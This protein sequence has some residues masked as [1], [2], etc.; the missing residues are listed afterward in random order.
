MLKKRHPFVIKFLTAQVVRDLLISLLGLLSILTKYNDKLV[1]SCI[2]IAAVLNFTTIYLLALK[3][4]TAA[5]ETNSLL[6]G[7]ISNIEITRRHHFNRNSVLFIFLLVA[8][9]SSLHYVYE[10]YLWSLVTHSCGAL[11]YLYTFW[12]LTKA[13]TSILKLRS[14]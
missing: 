6:H 11:M 4:R 1:A 14:W 3:I 9:A 5:Q 8:V 7:E 12:M 13:E 10:S 2:A